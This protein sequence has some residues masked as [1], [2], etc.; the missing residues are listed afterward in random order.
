MKFIITQKEVSLL[1]RHN[2]Q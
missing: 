2:S 1:E